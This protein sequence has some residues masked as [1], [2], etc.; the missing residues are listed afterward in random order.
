MVRKKRAGGLQRVEKTEKE[1][2]QAERLGLLMYDIQANV[3]FTAFMTAVATFFVGL[4]LTKYNSFDDTVRIPILFLIVSAFGFLYATLVYS[5][6]GGEVSHLKHKNYEKFTFLGN[7]LSEFCGIYFLILAIPLA[8]VAI[9]EDM[10]LRVAVL[11]VT[12]LGFIVYHVSGFAIISRYVKKHKIVS[13]ILPFFGI[14]L[15]LS[16]VYRPEYLTC[17]SVLTLVYIA[18]IIGY[19]VR[20]KHIYWW[21]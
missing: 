20:K 4:I 1:I 3:S 18:I 8:I 11:C 7:L 19:L 2:K 21:K 13:F 6:A 17:L 15:F 5:N 10:F 16:Q 12:Y 9:S 14:V